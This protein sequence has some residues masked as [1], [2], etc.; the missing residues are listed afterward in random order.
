VYAFRPLFARRRLV[1][2]RRRLAIFKFL[3][4]SLSLITPLCRS[5]DDAYYVYI[6]IYIYLSYSRRE[7]SS[8]LPLP[9]QL[10]TIHVCYCTAHSGIY[11]ITGTYVGPR[12]VYCAYRYTH[13]YNT[14]VGYAYTTHRPTRTANLK[15]TGHVFHRRLNGKLPCFYPLA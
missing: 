3:S 1:R 10:S 4:L 7:F 6:Y 11:N 8:G 2:R 5:R 15:S 13:Q 14:N 9:V 12:L